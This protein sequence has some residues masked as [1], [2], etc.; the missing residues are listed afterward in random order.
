MKPQV[1]DIGLKTLGN[2]AKKQW[3]VNY[4]NAK[5]RIQVPATPER[6]APIVTGPNFVSSYV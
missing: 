6:L 3:L 4:W 1:F 5:V 2:G